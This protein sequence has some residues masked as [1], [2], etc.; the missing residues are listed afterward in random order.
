MSLKQRKIK[1]EP[2]IKLNH[3]KSSGILFLDLFPVIL[4][5][6]IHRLK[7]QNHL[8]QHDKQYHTGKYCSVA[9]IL[10]V[11]LYDFIHRPKCSNHLVQHNKQYHRKVLPSSSHLNGCTLGFISRFRFRSILY[12]KLMYLLFDSSLKKI[13]SLPTALQTVPQ[14]STIQQL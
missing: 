4:Y 11:T 1:F 12:Y 7:S 6:F 8:A 14:E 2:R 10:M 5:E 13:K 3:N 9:F